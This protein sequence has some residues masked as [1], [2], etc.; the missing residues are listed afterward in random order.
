MLFLVGVV[1]TRIAK[2]NQA[3]ALLLSI[4]SN[5]LGVVTVPFML[6][7]LMNDS[8]PLRAVDLIGKL[9]LTVLLP[10]I[11]GYSWKTLSTSMKNFVNKH[12][13]ILS[14]ISANNLQC[15][16]GCHFNYYFYSNK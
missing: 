14:M 10:L 8:I 5:I 16:L 2:G 7:T 12:K 4:I 13:V 15:K 11:I 1:L 3:L 6:K 9:M